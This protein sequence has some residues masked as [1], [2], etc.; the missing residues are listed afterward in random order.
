MEVH[1]L[2]GWPAAAAAMCIDARLVHNAFVLNG[3]EGVL[4]REN[5]AF[6]SFFFWGGAVMRAKK[7]YLMLGEHSLLVMGFMS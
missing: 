7:V 6:Q 4:E 2:P 5:W 1:S 3:G